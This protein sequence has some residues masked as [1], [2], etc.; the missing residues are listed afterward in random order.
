MRVEKW[1][2]K[3]WRDQDLDR[4]KGGMVG[5]RRKIR[6]ESGI[7]EPYCGPSVRYIKLLVC[8][9]FGLLED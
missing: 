1:L 6:C 2:A 9:P 4:K 3:P 8:L 5:L 7:R